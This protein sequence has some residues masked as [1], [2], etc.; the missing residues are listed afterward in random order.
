[1]SYHLLFV[2]L[3]DYDSTLSVQFFSREMAT[4]FEQRGVRVTRQNFQETH[5]PQADVMLFHAYAGTPALNAFAA[6]K[7][8]EAYSALF[9]EH[10]LPFHCDHYFYYDAGEHPDFPASQ[11]T[12]IPIPI[13]KNSYPVRC[14][15]AGSILLDHD[16]EFFPQHNH[17]DH[18]W[19]LQFWEII[20]QR[21]SEF[22]DLF[23]LARGPASQRP[24]G[25]QVIPLMSQADYLEATS[26]FETFICT[27]AGSYNHTA[28]DMAIRGT[29]VLVPATSIGPFVPQPIV[30][31]LGMSVHTSPED[32]LTHA[33]DRS[34]STEP[35]LDKATDL[36]VVVERIDD[37]FRQVLLTRDGHSRK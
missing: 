7:P 10:P 36:D 28:L 12:F 35:Q 1:M 5:F 17:P 14:K 21:R 24:D 16:F 27:H 34:W 25:I 22:T 11:K 2:G 23:Q 18:D 8:S 26:Q 3:F 13:I 31:S 19:N 33:L 6:Q 20:D 32:L 37:H 30:E 4:R 15:R 9:M 29:R